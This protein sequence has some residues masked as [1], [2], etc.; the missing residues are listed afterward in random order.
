MAQTRFA[1]MSV[2]VL[3]FTSCGSDVTLAAPV[4]VGAW[5]RQG[6]C[7]RT[8]TQ[9]ANLTFAVQGATRVTAQAYTPASGTY[10]SR[11]A[12]SVDGGPW[13]VVEAPIS[14]HSQQIM[15]VPS[16][17]RA[18]HDIRVVVSGIHELSPFWSGDAGLI[19]CGVEGDA[20]A[21]SAT[22][23]KTALFMGDSITA[24]IVIRGH[25]KRK[26]YPATTPAQS[27]A[28]LAWPYLTA[29]GLGL[30]GCLRPISSEYPCCPLHQAHNR[31]S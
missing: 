2:V 5:V 29:T 30:R 10:P 17:S 18:H 11:L 25:D 19:W 16:L 15:L 27:A 31:W 24:G 14:D 22:P 20:L 12:V 21:P 3:C 13:N 28:E 6:D 23:T 9:G 1:M 7:Q 26:G 4:T 8:I